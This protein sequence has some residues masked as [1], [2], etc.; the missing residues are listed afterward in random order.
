MVTESTFVILIYP[1]AD[2]DNRLSRWVSGL[3][4]NTGFQQNSVTDSQVSNRYLSNRHNTNIF[5]RDTMRMKP[6]KKEEINIQVP[7]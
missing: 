2:E 7:E 1:L 3:I 4:W 6:A 5:M